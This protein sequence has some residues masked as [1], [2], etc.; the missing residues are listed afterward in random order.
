MAAAWGAGACDARS[1][2]NRPAADGAAEAPRPN[3]LLLVIDALRADRLGCYGYDRAL[4]PTLDEMA[5]E[6]VTFEQAVAQSPWTQPSMAALFT[7]MYPGALRPVDEFRVSFDAV[8]RGAKAVRVLDDRHPTLAAPLLAEGYATAAITANAYVTRAFG[9][10]QGFEHFD[11]SLAEA[12]SAGEDINEAAGRWLEGRDPGR[13]FFLYLHYMDVHGPYDAAPRFLEPLL[14]IVERMP[15]KKPLTPDQV[16]NLDPRYLYKLPK[17]H[18]N[19][20]RHERLMRFREYWV[21]RYEAGIAELDHHIAGLRE[22]LR[23][24]GLWDDLM[25][26]LT[27]DHGEALCEHGYWEHGFS[28]HHT[29]LHV[30][31]IVR[32]PGQLPA[33]RRVRETVRLMDVMP[34]VLDQIGVPLKRPVQ[35]VS[36]SSHITGRPPGEPV[37]LLAEGLKIPRS[38]VALYRGE[39]KL[40]LPIDPPVQLLYHFTEDPFERRNLARKHPEMLRRLVDLERAQR[41]ENDRLAATATREIMQLSSEQVDRLRSLG[42]VGETERE[43]DVHHED[44]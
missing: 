30:P 34:T 35:G 17:V 39:W 23:R 22:R 10:A 31:L 32:W 8:R 9:F 36:L 28:T 38:Q 6:G 5:A 33:G 11:A 4:T 14:D 19:K 2:S 18:T 3:I 1:S 44:P 37:T 27:S 21:A 20:A 26:I 7:G 25:V 41:A 12:E 15:D 16:A 40:A 13:P 24:V 29:E 43:T 42:Y